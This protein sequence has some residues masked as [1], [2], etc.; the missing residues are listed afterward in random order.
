ML[1]VHPSFRGLQ[2]PPICDWS[3]PKKQGS[4]GN[5]GS[6]KVECSLLSTSRVSRI[7]DSYP[8]LETVLNK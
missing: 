7:D 6:E 4:H 8:M 5:Q 2:A 3:G 1:I